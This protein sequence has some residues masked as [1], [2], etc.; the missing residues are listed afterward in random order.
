MLS[1]SVR[2]PCGRGSPLLVNFQ[3][4]QVPQGKEAEKG[5]KKDEVE[6]LA[7]M[8]KHLARP[9]DPDPAVLAERLRER[10]ARHRA[11][12]LPKSDD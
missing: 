5:K 2:R 12:T 11:A 9:I 8:A 1:R 3:T 6:K 10:L 7:I 4:L